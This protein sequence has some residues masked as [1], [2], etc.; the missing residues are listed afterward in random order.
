MPKYKYQALDNASA[1]IRLLR[2]E[3]SD[4]PTCLKGT[5]SHH[6]LQS[7]P[8]FVALSYEWGNPDVD[9][10]LQLNGRMIQIR[11]NLWAFLDVLV[12]KIRARQLSFQT[13]FWADSICIN[14]VDLNEKNSQVGL[15]GTIYSSAS[16]V[17]AWLGSP[18]FPQP[19]MVF[20]Y[21]LHGPEVVNSGYLDYRSPD[22]LHRARNID[23]V[24]ALS[25][26]RYWTRRWILQEVCLPAKVVVFWGSAE[27][28]FN[29]LLTSVQ[30]LLGSFNSGQ[31][32]LG[33]LHESALQRIARMSRLSQLKTLPLSELLSTFSD[34]E[35][36]TDAD[37]VY[38][39]RSLATQGRSIYVDYGITMEKLFHQVVVLSGWESEQALE[40]LEKALGIDESKL[41]SPWLFAWKRDHRQESRSTHDVPALLET[42]LQGMSH[43]RHILSLDIDAVNMRHLDW[44][45][46]TELSG[47]P[48]TRSSTRDPA[49]V[50][51]DLMTLQTLLV[52]E[53]Q[54]VPTRTFTPQIHHMQTFETI[55]RAAPGEDQMSFIARAA[56]QLKKLPG[57]QWIRHRNETGGW[58][59]ICDNGAIGVACKGARIGDF[60]C[61]TPFGH[62]LVVREETTLQPQ[63]VGTGWLSDKEAGQ[64]LR[65]LLLKTSSTRDA[66]LQRAK[67]D[68]ASRDGRVL[69]VNVRMDLLELIF[70]TRDRPWPTRHF[71]LHGRI[72]VVQEHSD[73]EMNH[74][75]MNHREA[76]TRPFDR[77]CHF[78][79]D[80][81]SERERYRVSAQDVGV[82]VV[83]SG[84]Q[85]DQTHVPVFHGLPCHG[86]SHC[87]CSCGERAVSD[88]GSHF[89][90][91]L[92][93]VFQN[94]PD[95]PITED[96]DG[97]KLVS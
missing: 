64:N 66:A 13:L 91:R 18:T 27:L 53:M 31:E 35:C 67:K 2:L 23:C 4:D 71:F 95:I 57:N 54:C 49:E 26:C 51:P 88:R 15:M 11:H 68:P 60:V 63:L 36:G 69:K 86:C 62:T 7:S 50:K 82:D 21:L 79:R 42:Q 44:L 17:Y 59:V 16:M 96:L 75:E 22:D 55:S 14:Q 56:E 70:L 93:Q 38:A 32:D 47:I 30:N 80:G 8:A 73:D 1:Q 87:L 12:A 43:I 19:E 37:R 5:L 58:V 65:T 89:K 29:D 90:H 78:N 74:D 41:V 6:S 40:R 72:W 48:D 34:L 9:L 39:V 97:L 81:S 20:R 46:C 24:L 52:K 45:S 76:R 10:D 84:S 83:D 25:Q 28:D 3:L 77:E 92:S 85:N 94:N 33:T 61:Q